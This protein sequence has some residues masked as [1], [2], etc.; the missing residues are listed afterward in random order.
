MILQQNKII[1]IILGFS[2]ASWISALINFIILPVSTRSFEPD[3]LAR[4]NLFY[5]VSTLITALSYWGFDQGYVRFYN[6]KS[7]LNDRKDLLSACL[8]ISGLFLISTS[9]LLLPFYEKISIWIS[10]KNEIFIILCLIVCS[11]SGMVMRY[12]SLLYRMENAV[13]LFT[14]VSV[15][16][17]SA[18]KLSYLISALVD[19]Q[20]MSAIII[21]TIT[22]SVNLLVFLV[23]NKKTINFKVSLRKNLTPSLV[24]FSLPLMPITIMAL[25]SNNI[26]LFILRSLDGLTQV[27]LFT[28]AVNLAAIITLLQSGLNIFWSPYV[29]K[30]YKKKT[31]SIKQ[32]HEIIVFLMVSFA[33]IITLLQPII[34]L[35]LGNSYR[36]ITSYLP[37]LLVSPVC[38]TIA[39]TTGIGIALKKKSFNNLIIYSVSLIT[40]IILC[41]IFIPLFSAKGAAIASAFAAILMLTLK[42][43]LGQRYYK[44]M[45]TY[46]FVVYAMSILIVSIFMSISTE[47]F[48]LNI[49]VNLALLI[50]LCFLVDIKKV[51]NLYFLKHKQQ[52]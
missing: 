13:I 17:S 25:L 29:Y 4:I 23:L 31:H 21:M 19:K 45:K 24:K 42:T 33:I 22:S 12:I 6:E 9:I 16:S 30:N 51:I 44:S 35:I 36:E 15:C 50:I 8:K 27:G 40:N 14:V 7:E 2:A 43:I 10:G 11:L 52:N 20:Y 3:Q 49:L 28:T 41:Y 34:V 46:K 48:M 39:E 1:R 47:I 38:Y 26:S 18:V 32:M 5:T 37:L